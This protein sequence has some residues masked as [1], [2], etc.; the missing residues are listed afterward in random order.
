[1]PMTTQDVVTTETV[2]SMVQAATE[3]TYGARQAFRGHNGTVAGPD[4]TFPIT[5]EDFEGAMS[6]IPEGSEYPRFT[7]AYGDKKVTYT[8]YGFEFDLTDEAIDD[9]V[10]DIRLDQLSDAARE[11]TRHLDQIAYDVLDANQRENPVG[12]GEG[13]MNFDDIIDARAL[14]RNDDYD[15]DLLLLEPFGGA[16]ILKADEFKLRDTPVGDRV[17]TQGFLGSIAGFDIF[18][19][20]ARHGLEAN[21]GI[22]VDTDHYGYESTKFSNR[23]EEYREEEKD[24]T[25]WQI[26][27]RLGWLS[28]DSEAALK[29]EG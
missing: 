9:G 24:T 17:V 27:D 10:L 11:E 28:M 25:V 29:I 18:E 6:E 12:S 19:M 23:V 21:H 5:T 26:A 2:E 7:K 22:M 8:K 14:M 15:P 20:T 13:A 1:M 3:A 16:E 4:M